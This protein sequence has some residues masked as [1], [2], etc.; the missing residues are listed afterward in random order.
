[1]NFGCSPLAIVSLEAPPAPS[2]LLGFGL[3][4]LKVH[5]LLLQKVPGELNDELTTS[6]AMGRKLVH[7]IGHV[8]QKC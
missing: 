7:G 8:L 5:D 2:D 4:G 6:D 3:G 1:L